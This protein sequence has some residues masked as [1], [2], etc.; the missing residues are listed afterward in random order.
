MHLIYAN[1]TYDDILLKV[2]CSSLSPVCELN[3]ALEMFVEN[4]IGID[5]IWPLCF[6]LNV[7]T[8][9]P[10]NSIGA[11]D[12][13]VAYGLGLLMKL[14]WWKCFINLENKNQCQGA[15]D[16]NTG[17]KL[18]QSIYCSCSL[19]FSFYGYFVVRNYIN[20]SKLFMI[21]NT[22]SFFLQDEI[23]S[24]AKNYP[25]Q[26]QVYYV[27]NQAS[28]PSVNP[29]MKQSGQLHFY[30]DCFLCFSLVAR[31]SVRK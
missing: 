4:V 10:R 23:D 26:F 6:H 22:R 27:L 7:A 18:V 16:N 25:D 19:G 15:A 3:D 1:V 24:L 13:S 5:W 17:A 28:L 21:L 9:V 11:Q 14:V 8:T 30:L 2:I 20:L 12:N 31:L 29:T